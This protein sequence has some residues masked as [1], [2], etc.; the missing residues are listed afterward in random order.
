M[1]KHDVFL[2][3]PHLGKKWRFS[4]PYIIHRIPQLSQFLTIHSSQYRENFDRF[5][6]SNC[7]KL[8]FFLD[9]RDFDY[10]EIFFGHPRPD[11]RGLTVPSNDGPVLN[12]IRI[13]IHLKN[14]IS[15]KAYLNT[16]LD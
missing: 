15:L 3:I 6:Q 1:L 11:N 5:E 7:H 8:I 2:K 9:Y 14:K 12:C 4:L 16:Y 13:H 10:R